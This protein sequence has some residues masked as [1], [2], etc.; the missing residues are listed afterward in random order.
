MSAIILKREF[1]G[2]GRGAA[3]AGKGIHGVK[4]DLGKEGN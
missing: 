2:S 4:F 3:F 1:V